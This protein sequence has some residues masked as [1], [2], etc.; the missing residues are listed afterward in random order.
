MF[1]LL[2]AVFLFGCLNDKKLVD[3]TEVPK[4]RKVKFIEFKTNT[5]FAPFKLLTI[6]LGNFEIIDASIFENKVCI[7]EKN[8]LSI[9]NHSGKLLLNYFVDN[10][11]EK[12][13]F[14]GKSI[15]LIKDNRCDFFVFQN[16]KLVKNSTLEVKNTIYKVFLV[17]DNLIIVTKT[18]YVSWFS[19]DGKKLK[20]VSLNLLFSP[21]NCC[22]DR[23][24]NFLITSN[25]FLYIFSKDGVIVNLVQ[26]NNIGSPSGVF[27]GEGRN[28]SKSNSVCVFSK[29]NI[30][31][32]LEDNKNFKRYQLKNRSVSVFED[33]LFVNCKGYL[34]KGSLADLYFDKGLEKI[35]FGR[36][37]KIIGKDLLLF[38]DGL[39][40]YKGNRIAEKVNFFRTKGGLLLL[41]ENSKV[42]LVRIIENE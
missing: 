24:N 33:Q 11:Y 6:N 13:F 36:Y 18:G 34:L 37:V 42:S 25:N 30:F 10:T 31:L 16:D 35:D 28:S 9:F 19:K 14:F 4:N 40:E 39:V 41:R 1:H 12:M 5:T 26:L 3:Y 22:I 2:L 23:N 27:V 17:K 21:L 38:N 29:D 15:A 20:D 32:S 7:L 8:K